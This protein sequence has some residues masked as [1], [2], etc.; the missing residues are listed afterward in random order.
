MGGTPHHCHRQAEDPKVGEVALGRFE[1]EGK[2]LVMS[3]D[4]FIE[5]SRSSYSI[6]NS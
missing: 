1:K 5:T 6:K 4:L 2:E 3:Y